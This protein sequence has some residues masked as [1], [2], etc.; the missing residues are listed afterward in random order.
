[1]MLSLYLK[2]CFFFAALH[3][4]GI[5]L[6]AWPNP[7]EA[8]A[9]VGEESETQALVRTDAMTTLGSPVA[10]VEEVASLSAGLARASP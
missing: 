5:D 9:H 7:W 8:R 4:C 2:V 3:P 1:M 10:L 6:R